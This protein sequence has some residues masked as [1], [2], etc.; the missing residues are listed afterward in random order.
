MRKFIITCLFIT[1]FV[2]LTG[3]EHKKN[4]NIMFEEQLKGLKSTKTY[5]DVQAS[6]ISSLNKWLADSLEDVQVLNDCNWKLDDAVLFNSKKDRCFLLLLIQDKDPKAELD[7]VYVMY[8]ALENGKW[9]IYYDALPGLVFPRDRYSKNKNAP[10][11]LDTLSKAGRE[12]ALRGYYMNNG[13]INDEYV[14]KVYTAD[15]RKRHE[16]FLN[17]KI[18]R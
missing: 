3:C 9:T 10:I 14:E 13:S 16:E 7:Y 1:S 8:G 4:E 17:K 11:P 15:F 6:A 18:S 5:Q 12:E 2:F